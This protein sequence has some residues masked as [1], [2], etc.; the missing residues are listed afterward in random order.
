MEEQ[1]DSYCFLC[2]EEH[3]MT[4]QCVVLNAKCKGCGEI[5]HLSK[6]CPNVEGP[7]SD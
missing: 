4:D 6:D 3:I 2:Q 5:G 1:Q 7:V